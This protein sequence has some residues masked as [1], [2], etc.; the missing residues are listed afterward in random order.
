[1]C[2]LHPDK[3]WIYPRVFLEDSNSCLLILFNATSIL[4]LILI[5][6]DM[7]FLISWPLTSLPS[8]YSK[9]ISSTQP[10][11]L[12]SSMAPS[13]LWL[14]VGQ[15]FHHLNSGIPYLDH[16][17]SL[18]NAFASCANS[19]KLEPY[20]DPMDPTLLSLPLTTSCAHVPLYPARSLC[21]TIIIHLSHMP[22]IPLTSFFFRIIWLK[23]IPA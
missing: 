13:D 7:I 15:P 17:L 14:L 10:Q 5:P 4:N 6:L 19:Y 21:S 3:A 16:D 18:G 2:K 8:S 12:I 1:M 11:S 20:P 23:T 9:T 22:S